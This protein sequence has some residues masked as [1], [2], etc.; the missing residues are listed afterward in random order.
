MEKNR[1]LSVDQSLLLASQFSVHLIDFLSILFRCNDFSGIQKAVVDQTNSQPPNSDDDLF[2]V[3][4][5]L[6]EVLWCFLSFQPLTSYY[7]L[8]YKILFCHTSQNG[9]E[10]VPCC[11]C[12]EWEDVTPKWWYFVFFDQF[13]RHHLNFFTFPIC[14][15]CQTTI[16]WSALSSWA[17]SWVV[18]KGSASM[19]AL[20]C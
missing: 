1:D 17:N 20:H 13:M 16:E 11:C 9:Q 6:W 7:Q 10:M 18:V 14:F 5:W 3:K 19:I 15:K 12:T 2:L 8:L 4:V